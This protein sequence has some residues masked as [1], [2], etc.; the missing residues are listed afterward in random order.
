MKFDFE[1]SF[2]NDGTWWNQQFSFDQQGTHS[3]RVGFT[4]FTLCRGVAVLPPVT[5][6]NCC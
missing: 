1:L 5:A 2:L 6:L 4:V 3:A